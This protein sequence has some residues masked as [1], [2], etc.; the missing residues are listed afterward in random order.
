L[1]DYKDLLNFEKEKNEI[2]AIRKLIS[3]EEDSFIRRWLYPKVYRTDKSI[4]HKLKEIESKI[5]DETEKPVYSSGHAFV[6]FDSLEAAYKCLSRFQEKTFSKLVIQFKTFYEKTKAQRKM[7]STFGRFQDELDNEILEPDNVHIIVDQMVEPGDIIWSNVG[8][9]RGVYFVRRILLNIAVFL[10]LIFLTT[11][12]VRFYIIVD[13]I[14]SCKI[15][16]S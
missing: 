2:T 4:D 9:N 14:L 5:L 11:P 15:K 13:F 16:H 8:G 6:C 1:P 10:I 7:T 12:T 3:Q